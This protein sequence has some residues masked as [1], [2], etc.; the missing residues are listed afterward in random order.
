MKT[1]IIIILLEIII[2]TNQYI[3][4]KKHLKKIL[5]KNEYENK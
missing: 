1:L 5:K 3:L 2:L 4:I